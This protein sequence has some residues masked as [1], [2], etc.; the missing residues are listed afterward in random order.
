[1]TYHATHEFR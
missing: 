1:M